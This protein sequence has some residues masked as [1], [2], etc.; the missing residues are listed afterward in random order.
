MREMVGAICLVGVFLPTI[1]CAELSEILVFQGRGNWSIDGAGHDENVRLQVPSHSKIVKAYLYVHT[2]PLLQQIP[3]PMVQF[4]DSTYEGDDWVALTFVHFPGYDTGMQAYRSDVTPHVKSLVA[5]T[6][7]ELINVPVD[8]EWPFTGTNG[9]ILVVIYKN[10]QESFRNIVIL[11]GGAETTGDSF[12]FQLSKPADPSLESFEALFSV[13]IGFSV[14][15]FVQTTELFVDGRLLTVSAGGD[16]D[17]GQLVTVGGIGDD[18]SNPRYPA[19]YCSSHQ[20]C[21]DDEL[22]DL[23]QG[24]AQDASPYLAADQQ[25]ISVASINI[26]ENDNLFFAGINVVIPPNPVAVLMRR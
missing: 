9:V 25:V 3:P 19:L 1:V 2:A 20:A 7:D 21:A 5:S 16:D 6:T 23:A 8:Y 17:G 11:D 15:N 12:E 24:N 14:G 22:Y 26:G 18:P 10:A 4:G 13:G